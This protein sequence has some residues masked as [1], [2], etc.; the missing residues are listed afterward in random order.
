MISVEVRSS[1][2][3]PNADRWTQRAGVGLT[4]LASAVDY[5]KRMAPRDGISIIIRREQ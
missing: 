2:N 1:G 5:I 3:A 4:W